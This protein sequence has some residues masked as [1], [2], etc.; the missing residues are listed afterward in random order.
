MAA[1]GLAGAG[2]VLLPGD[3]VRAGLERLFALDA[4]FDSALW[5]LMHPDLRHTARIKALADFLY[6]GLR[7]DPRLL[8]F[9]SPQ[10]APAAP[11]ATK[12]AR[13]R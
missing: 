6:E 2:V 1:L 12:R 7:T 5:L 3:Q 9:Q 10:G 11:S 8:P 4:R 13:R